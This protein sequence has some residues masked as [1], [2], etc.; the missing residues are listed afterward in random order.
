MS[1]SRDTRPLGEGQIVLEVGSDLR[2]PPVLRFVT[3]QRADVD[4]LSTRYVQGH[5]RRQLKDDY[6]IRN[7]SCSLGA[8]FRE[9]IGA[10]P[11]I[12]GYHQSA[13]LRFAIDEIHAVCKV[14]G[15]QPETDVRRSF[16]LLRLEISDGTGFRLRG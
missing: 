4:G 7:T 1:C 16:R 2:E 11:Y 5:R 8:V 13:F 10:I 3:L 12:N 9:N 14:Q 15:P 6:P